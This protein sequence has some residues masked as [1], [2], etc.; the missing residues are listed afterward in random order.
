MFLGRYGSGKC[1]IARRFAHGDFQD[2]IVSFE[3]GIELADKLKIPF[4]ATSAKENINI[5]LL[6]T[7]LIRGI[8]LQ[9]LLYKQNFE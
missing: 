1:S 5:H 7:F 9:Q 4:L 8:C 3:E 2:D 6:F